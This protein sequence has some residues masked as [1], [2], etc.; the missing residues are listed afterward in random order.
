VAVGVDG[1]VRES[2]VDV[3]ELGGRCRGLVHR[4]CNMG[5]PVVARRRTLG[6]R[7]VEELGDAKL[8]VE[9][10]VLARSGDWRRGGRRRGGCHQDAGDVVG[11]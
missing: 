3:G 7:G 5:A 10:P 6:V 1:R 11:V 9:S 8:E 2:V 4:H